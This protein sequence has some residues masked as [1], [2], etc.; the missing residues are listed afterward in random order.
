MTPTC[1]TIAFDYAVNDY[2]TG[3][4]QVSPSFILQS[5]GAT[6]YSDT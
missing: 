2:T 3:T 4:L 5:A 1:T 6:Q